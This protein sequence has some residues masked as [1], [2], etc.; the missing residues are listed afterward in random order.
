LS[1]HGCVRAGV[2]AGSHQRACDDEAPRAHRPS[3]WKGSHPDVTHRS[4]SIRDLVSVDV[5]L[6]R[7]MAI[8]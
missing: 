5:K 3:R 2:R 6:V 4:G 1:R 7:V 8:V